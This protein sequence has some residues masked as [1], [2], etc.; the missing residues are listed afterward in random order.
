MLP[1]IIIKPDHVFE[2]LL[3]QLELAWVHAHFTASWTPFKRHILEHASSNFGPGAVL[4]KLFSL[5]KLQMVQ[6]S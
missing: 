4:T 5:C 6:L 2:I 3:S 1:K